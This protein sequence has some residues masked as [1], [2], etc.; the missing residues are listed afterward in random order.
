[1]HEL[2]STRW[3]V[4]DYLP[5]QQGLRPP[6]YMSFL[7]N[8]R[9]PRLSSITTRIKTPK[10]CRGFQLPQQGPRLS[11]ITTRIKTYPG[12][13]LFSLLPRRPRLSSITT[14]IK[15]KHSLDRHTRSV[16][17]RDYLPLQ[18]GLRPSSARLL[19]CRCQR[20]ETIFHYNKD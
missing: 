20:S 12:L 3:F 14:R 1:M 6:L 16:D 9:C 18:Q 5:L 10:S 13:S 2:N 8:I 15:T 11:S 7:I 4:R 19:G 17:V